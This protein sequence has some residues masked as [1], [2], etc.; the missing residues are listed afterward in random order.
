MSD[1]F[2]IY[3]INGTEDEEA[4]F[5]A[6]SAERQA[7]VRAASAETV[8]R[9]RLFSSFLLEFLLRE[10]GYAGVLHY[11]YTKRGKPYIEGGPCFS[12]SHSYPFIAAA[13]ADEPVGI[14]IE[15]LDEAKRKGWKAV[16]RSRFGSLHGKQWAET[17]DF[18]SF[19]SYFT[20]A[21]AYAKMKDIPLTE[22][23]AGENWEEKA[24]AVS[25]TKRAGSCIYTVAGPALK[26]SSPPLGL[27]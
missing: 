12:I 18:G 23:L 22:L 11:S 5:S 27:S 24:A 25:V 7:H 20:R 13:V 9:E 21:E 15:L 19:L 6:L 2:C 14:D 16:A 26:E 4:L 8:R 1:L 3:E 10:A 17:G